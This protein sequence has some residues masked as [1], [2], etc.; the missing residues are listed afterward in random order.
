M[1][2]WITVLLLAEMGVIGCT[3]AQTHTLPLGTPNTNAIQTV[4]EEEYSRISKHILDRVA[5]L[6]EA[7]PTLSNMT[8]AA[9]Y[10]YN[11]TWVLDDPTK[12]HSKLNG[13][14]AVFGKDGYWFSLQFYRGQWGGA[15]F[16]VPIEFGD[17][18]LWFQ[19]GH[20]G[21]TTEIAAITSIL[22][23]ENEAFCRKHPWQSP[24]QSL[25]ATGKPAP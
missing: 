5:A 9:H 18:K 17:L 10:E 20:G 14:H 21:N 12:P 7:Y 19:F 25:K 1:M 3:L 16:F 15:A 23:E 13:R 6:K 4:S 11:V 8:S 2:K 22:R 24:N